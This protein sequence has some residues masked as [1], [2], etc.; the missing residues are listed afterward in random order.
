MEVCA[1]GIE[2]KHW[3]RVEEN[4]HASGMV[5]LQA[6]GRP[7]PTLLLFKY[8]RKVSKL[9]NSQRKWDR[10]SRI[11]GQEGADAHTYGTFY[12]VVMQATILFRSETWV[13]TPQI[14]L[15]L[16]GFHRRLDCWLVGMKLYCEEKGHWEY[17]LMLDATTAAGLEEV[18]T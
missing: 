4:T 6:Y 1:K 17:L 9:R 10:M 16:W 18:E 12:K 3:W 5:A 14:G 2:R 7:T 13:T 11:F 15:T 8:L